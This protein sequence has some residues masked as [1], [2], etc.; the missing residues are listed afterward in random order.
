MKIFACLL[1]YVSITFYSQN[2]Q[3]QNKFII[4]I[5]IPSHISANQLGIEYDNGKKVIEKTPVFIHSK[6]VITDSFYSKYAI[7]TITYPDTNNILF[8][9]RFFIS[10]KNSLIKFLEKNRGIYHK[11]PLLN[12][13]SVNAIEISKTVDA[14]KL[15][16]YA[17]S[18]LEEVE[19][20]FLRYG[21]ISGD[22]DSLNL[23][24]NIKERT[25]NDKRLEFIKMNS[26]SYY[27]FWL[28]RTEIAPL[29]FYKLPD[30]L[31][32]IFNNVFPNKIKSSIEG[33]EIYKLLWGRTYIK[34]GFLAPTFHAKD[35]L[36][37]NIVLEELKGKFILINFWASWCIPCIQHIIKLKEIQPKLE[38]AN[39]QIISISY[40]KD[41][42]K[43]KDAVLKYQM[44]WKNIFNDEDLINKY[45]RKPIP[46]L[47]LID[48]NGKIIC[49]NYEDGDDHLFSILNNLI[50]K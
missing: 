34:N 31:L 6:M 43:F 25:L 12:F 38:A 46:A 45:G 14:K 41:F 18:E 36:G 5:I 47:Y 17:K 20:I 4:E 15:A 39:L 28:F 26:H 1:T 50:L 23:M 24:L 48:Q 42:S 27:S 22:M 13:N 16:L 44:N 10:E 11:N 7:L 35:F 19:D 29:L 40:D 21:S 32:A 37:K 8:T 9:N 49:N 30:S 3:G 2:L 33:Q